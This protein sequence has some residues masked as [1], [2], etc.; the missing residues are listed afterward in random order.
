MSLS[1][2]SLRFKI[3]RRCSSSRALASTTASADK[4]TAGPEDDQWTFERSDAVL[5]EAVNEG[6]TLV[7][8]LAVL[9][10]TGNHIAQCNGDRFVLAG[11]LA[12]LLTD[13]VN[14]TNPWVPFAGQDELWSDEGLLGLAASWPRLAAGGTSIADATIKGVAE[15]YAE[16]GF[17][18]EIV[19]G[20]EG[21]RAYA[22]AV[23]AA[24]PR[25]RGGR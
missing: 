1:H 13:A 20:D 8:P 7:L 18:V 21:L 23:P 24:L 12:Q 2:S 14:G 16:A 19:T 25:R 10:E 3:K 11:Q 6:A 9:I 15:F 4:D 5:R 17:Q 22:P